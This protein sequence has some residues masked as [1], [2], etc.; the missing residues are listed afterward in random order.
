MFWW[1]SGRAS[2]MQLCIII[3]HSLSACRLGDTYLSVLCLDSVMWV[4]GC[5]TLS[6]LRVRTQGRCQCCPAES[7]IKNNWNNTHCDCGCNCSPFCQSVHIGTWLVKLLLLT[8]L[9][10]LPCINSSALTRPVQFPHCG[11][12]PKMPLVLLAT[13]TAQHPFYDFYILH[14]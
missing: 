6:L 9:L 12:L 7:I 8:L 4:L 2:V 1:Q 3:L 5:W 11:L 10:T 13:G 14:K